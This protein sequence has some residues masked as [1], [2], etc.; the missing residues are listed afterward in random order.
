V[1]F[2][3]NYSVE[4]VNLLDHAQV[5]FDLFKCPAWPAVI[6]ES[7]AHHP[8]YVHFPLRVGAGTGEALNSENHGQV[9]W[10][11]VDEMR[12]ST[13][14]PL[15]NL[16]LNPNEGEHPG[17]LTEAIDRVSAAELTDAFVRDV[18]AVVSQYGPQHVVV[19]ND[20]SCAY[21]AG[22]LPE[23]ISRVV[24]ETGC[25]FVLDLSHAQLAASRLGLEPHD[26]TLSLPVTR[27]REIHVSGNQRLE[28]KWL[29]RVR[30]AG[31]LTGWIAQYEGRVIDHLPMTD[32]DWDFA[33]WALQQV[34]T[35]AWSEPWVIA[36]EYGGIGAWFQA[37]TD[38]DVLHVQV[39][40][41]RD[42]VRGA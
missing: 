3:V 31:A 13:N 24:E 10:A 7:Q 36:F 15:V 2:A 35:G 33:A 40:R 30:N 1:E 9:D 23:V 38:A 6:A 41:L 27:V 17:L 32:S 14:T 21:A 22:I 18:S 29:D 8:T 34:H 16:H 5:Q 42:L 19:E 20:Y 11:S 12:V 39:P 37:V 26:Y 28:G 4:L 25:G